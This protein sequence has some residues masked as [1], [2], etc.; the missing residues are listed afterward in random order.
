[1]VEPLDEELYSLRLKYQDLEERLHDLE[2]EF[3]TFV[4]TPWWKRLL[5]SLNGWPLYRLVD[6]PQWR[7]WHRWT[8]WG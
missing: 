8:G 2:E 4:K 3:D 1:M 5:F 6:H 7:P